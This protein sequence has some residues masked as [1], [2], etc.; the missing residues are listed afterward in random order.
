MSSRTSIQKHIVIV[1]TA[2]TDILT[3]ERAMATLDI[4]DL[5]NVRVFNPVT[6]IDNQPEND[7]LAAL[8]NAG[9]VVL[10]LLGGKSAMGETFGELVS[11]CR[12]HNIPLIACPGH[13]EWDEDLISA[14]S[15]PVSELETTFSYLMQAGVQNFGNLILFLSDSY[16][17]RNYGHLS[18]IHI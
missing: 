4:P 18:L 1:T 3:I 5:P 16:L 12:E 6:N 2:D 10:R 14:C 7:V 9:V 11:Y 15:V 17:D 8:E 13:Q